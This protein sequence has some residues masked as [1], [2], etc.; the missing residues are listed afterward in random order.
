MRW[1][2]RLR[3]RARLLADRSAMER[4][5]DDEMRFHLEMEAEELARFGATSQE[6]QRAARLHFGGLARYKDEAREARVGRW[7]EELRQDARYARRV[8]ARS[9]GFSIVA[10]LTL[11]LGIGANTAIFSVVRGV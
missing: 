11:A 1:L 7:L 3:R 8:L 4:E 5:L 10:A 6:A 9:R 2:A